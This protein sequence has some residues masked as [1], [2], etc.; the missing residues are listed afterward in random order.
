M[1]Y[2]ILNKQSNNCQIGYSRSRMCILL[3]MIT[4]YFMILRFYSL[5]WIFF[6]IM[7]CSCTD[8]KPFVQDIINID[9][10]KLEIIKREDDIS[11]FEYTRD[12]LERELNYKEGQILYLRS[13][14]AKNIKQYHTKSLKERI[15]T[16][17]NNLK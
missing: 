8:T 10:L 9:S 13:E 3:I 4:Q 5:M 11:M 2:L 7:L 12:S 15:E 17:T 16:L 1:I 14:L 6:M